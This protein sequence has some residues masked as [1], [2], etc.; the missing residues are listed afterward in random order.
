MTETNLTV[1][2]IDPSR[3]RAALRPTDP[4]AGRCPVPPGGYRSYLSP[5]NGGNDVSTSVSYTHLTL[6]TKAEV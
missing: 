1:A 5:G 4:S 3:A 6:P 2:V